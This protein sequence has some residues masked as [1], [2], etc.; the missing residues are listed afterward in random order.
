MSS[1]G[2]RPQALLWSMRM[3][4]SE[5]TGRLGSLEVGQVL[6]ENRHGLVVDME[7]SE[8][9][10]YAPAIALCPATLGSEGG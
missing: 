8:A 5:T 9:Y 10:G 4:R 6:T 2:R 3:F 7:L 1:A